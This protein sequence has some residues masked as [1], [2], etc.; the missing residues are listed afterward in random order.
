MP[1]T[2]ESLFAERTKWMRA[3]DVREILKYTEMPGII[4][5]GGGLPSPDSFPLEDIRS[6]FEELVREPNAGAF[7]YGPTPGD[8]RL[9]AALADRLR[10]RGVTVEPDGVIVTHGAQQAIELLGRVLLDAGDTVVTTEPTYLGL[11]T[12]LATYRP[13][14]H[15]VRMDDE[16]LL[17]D[18]LED[19][20]RALDRKGVHPK[21][22]YVVP[23]FHNPAGVTMSARRRRHLAGLAA[24]YRVLVVEDDPYYDLRFEGEDLPPVASADKEG[25]VLSVGSFSKILAPGF[26]VGW[27]A[28]HPD[29]IGKMSLAKQGVDLF[30]NSFGQRVAERYLRHGMLERHLPKVRAMYRRKR[31]L[32]LVAMEA[33]F[34]E[35]VSWTR[36][37]GGMFLWVTLPPGVDTKPLLPKAAERGVV[38]V[39]GH[40]F[41][42]G[43]PE[44]NHMRLNYS[45]PSEAD[46][47]RAIEA[48]G[49]VLS[50]ATEPVG[51][52][53]VGG[54]SGARSPRPPRPRRPRC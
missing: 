1:A 44:V 6:I 11:F 13:S 50:E 30:T 52:V 15:G 41:F 35:G 47:P 25:W 3:S 5:L 9:R 54:A 43:P 23:T 2:V 16:G 51:T 42:P 4:S 14:Y 46:I 28:G 22:L 39:P 17:T 21:F 27:A 36:P 32:M 29:V 49:G 37:Q 18:I 19:D 24:E 53:S 40:G 31:D 33:H 20:L 10:S 45:Y 34:P 7:Q 38:F 8:A 12:A 26:R 48:L